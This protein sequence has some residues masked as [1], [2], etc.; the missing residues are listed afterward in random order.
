MIKNKTDYNIAV[1]QLNQWTKEYDEGQPSVSDKTWDDLY[2]DV[3]DFEDSTDFIS[4]DSPTQKVTYDVINKLKKVKHNHLMLSLE[5]TKSIDELSSI[6][7][8]K[9][10]IAM[11]KLDG[12]SCS[13]WYKNGKL[14]Q[15]ET[16]GDGEIGEDVTH[17]AKVV[18]NIPKEIS[19]TN[20]DVIIDGEIICN[21]FDF[22]EFKDV[23]KNPRNFAS[24]SIRLLDSRVCER[25]KLSFIAWDAIK[26]IE[27][28]TLSFKLHIL[29]ELGFETP[30]WTTSDAPAAPTFE[31]AIK[32]IKENSKSSGYPIDG[33][34]FKLDNIKEYED[35][36]M[37]SHGANRNAA[38]AY[39][40]YEETYTS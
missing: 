24:G 20:H 28:D 36:G 21:K 19:I 32:Y 35:Y 14:Y 39:K 16:R 13:L 31:S 4:P 25:R 37:T 38:I 9:T 18:R 33:V 6:F 2:F 15:A 22:E 3:K 10:W 40:F 5:K 34:V 7:K 11:S 17:N 12:L 30:W 26:G 1:T 23:Y 8:N 29:S 27:S